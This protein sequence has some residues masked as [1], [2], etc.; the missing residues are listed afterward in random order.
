MVSPDLPVVT[1]DYEPSSVKLN[2]FHDKVPGFIDGTD[3]PRAF[4][5]ECIEIIAVR[6]PKIKAFVVKMSL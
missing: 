6:E 2:T 1:R 3:T 5:E 4:L